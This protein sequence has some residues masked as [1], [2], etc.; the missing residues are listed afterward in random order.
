MNA[1]VI[2][3]KASDKTAWDICLLLKK[4]GILAKPTHQNIIR[5]APPL[6]ITDE[7]MA[8]AIEAIR[9]TFKEALEIPVDQIPG[10][11]H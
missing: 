10:R 11:D 8:S 4:N 3:E 1:V 7:E 9:K 5:L 2:D 6:C